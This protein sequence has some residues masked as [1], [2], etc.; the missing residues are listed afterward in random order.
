M[1]TA[2]PL[3]GREQEMTLRIPGSTAA[4]AE[5]GATLLIEPLTAREREVLAHLERLTEREREVLTRLPPRLAKLGDEM[6]RS[7]NTV[8]THLRTIYRKLPANSRGEAVRAR[9][10]RE[11]SAK[12][13]VRSADGLLA[14]GAGLLPASD[15]A[16]YAEEYRS[17]LWDLAQAGA[18]RIKQLRYA[19]CQLR[20][21][22]SMSVTLRSPRR[23]SSTP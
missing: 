20:N 21:A 14:A 10:S 3:G 4:E 16:R 15:R 22:F 23:R 5:A 19:L 7:V 13:V 9:D 1:S 18:G 11:S 12:K 6:Y 2:E 17:E 8:K